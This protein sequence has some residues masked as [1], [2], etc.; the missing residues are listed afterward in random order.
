[1]GRGRSVK[2]SNGCCAFA[3]VDRRIEWHGS[4]KDEKGME[5]R[6]GQMLIEIDARYFRPTEVDLLVG[7]LL[8]ARKVC[9]WG[10]LP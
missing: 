3:C 5:A 9:C 4:G 1:V 2:S 10:S 6:S 7:D 8:N